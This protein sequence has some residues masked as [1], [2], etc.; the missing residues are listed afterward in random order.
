MID[1][2]HVVGP[3]STLRCPRCRA[4]IASYF[5][6][7]G[8]NEGHAHCENN[9]SETRRLVG[10]TCTWLGQVRKIADTPETYLLLEE[11]GGLAVPTPPP[12]DTPVVDPD[13]WFL[14]ENYPITGYGDL[15]PD[16]WPESLQLRSRSGDDGWCWYDRHRAL[17]LDIQAAQSSP[18]WL[19][20]GRLGMGE[21]PLGAHYVRHEELAAAIRV[22]LRE[23]GAGRS[24]SSPPVTPPWLFETLSFLQRIARGDP[25]MGRFTW[26]WERETSRLYVMGQGSEQYVTSIPMEARSRAEAFCQLLG[27]RL[28][29]GVG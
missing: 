25:D 29:D 2:S 24:V 6:N 14:W 26:C 12:P 20:H 5:S 1:P 21:R 10:G 7:G 15:Q 16:G 27:V 28:I 17:P 19:F 22:L 23:V 13:A 18:V 8:D 4:L 3:L 11:E 9:P